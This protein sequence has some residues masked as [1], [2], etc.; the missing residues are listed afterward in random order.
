MVDKIYLNKTLYKTGK[1]DAK[2]SLFVDALI[3]Y[4]ASPTKSTEKSYKQ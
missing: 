2:F 4:Q 3:V 1:K